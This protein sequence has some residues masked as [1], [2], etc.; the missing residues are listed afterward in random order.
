MK[1]SGSLSKPM[2][3]LNQMNSFFPTCQVRVSRFYMLLSELLPHSPPSSSPSPPAASDPE[4]ELQISVGTAGPQP[5]ATETGRS[6]S[7]S[8]S[9]HVSMSE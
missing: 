6:R 2:I 1:G 4:R 3:R 5:R 8:A 9:A 7:K